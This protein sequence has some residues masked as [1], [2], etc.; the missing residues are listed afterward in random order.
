MHI[1]Y[2]PGKKNMNADALSQS[3]FPIQSVEDEFME[4]VSQTMVAAVQTEEPMLQDR[5]DSLGKRQRDDPD[6]AEMEFYIEWKETT[7]FVLSLPRMIER[8]FLT[9]HTVESLVVIFVRTKFVQLSKHY[10]WSGMRS[11]IGRWCGAC[12]MCATRRVG[13][14]VK[15]LLT[16]IPVRGPFDRMGVDVLQ[17][18][19]STRGHQYALV[20][21]DY[22]T[23]WPEVFRFLLYIYI[24]NMCSY[25]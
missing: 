5:E 15:P 17:M 19:I 10:W 1:H 2:R 23:K 11:D 13:R 8:S 16:P 18:P 6:L 4:D 25:A 22:L 20:F 3:P 21:M 12:L 14:G 24:Y 7:L 9:R